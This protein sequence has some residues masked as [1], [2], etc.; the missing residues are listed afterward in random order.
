M[1]DIPAWVY[2]N[3]CLGAGVSL[4]PFFVNTH[5]VT[6]VINCAFS[7]DSPAWFRQLYPSRYAQLNAHDSVNVKILDW[8][9]QF[10]TAL[11]SFL[12]APNA[13]VFV[14]CQ[15]GINRSAFLLLY[16]MCKNFGLDLATMVSAVRKQ[17]PQICQN[18][19]FMQEVTEALKAPKAP[20]AST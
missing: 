13:I 16:Y 3:I 17:R 19:A 15:A 9:P 12:R 14:H 5:Q 7:E 18:P 6:H 10:E 2:P 20:K 4:T 8:Y 11:R 1:N